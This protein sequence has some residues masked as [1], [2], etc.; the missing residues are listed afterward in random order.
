MEQENLFEEGEEL[1]ETVRKHFLVY[2]ADVLIHSF[3]CIIFI[4]AASFLSSRQEMMGS[5]IAYILIFFVITF[6]TSFF[7]AW[8]KNYLDLWYITDKHII[9]IDQKDMLQR[10]KLLWNLSEF[11]M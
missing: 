1:L 11:K 7:Y 5:Y 9:A 4:G 6:W 2:L 3:A 8:T 10:K